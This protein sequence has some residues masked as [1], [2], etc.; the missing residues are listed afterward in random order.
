LETGVLRFLKPGVGEVLGPGACS[1][2]AYP[3]SR[4][5]RGGRSHKIARQ[6]G[7]ARS[8]TASTPPA[9][10]GQAVAVLL[11]SSTLRPA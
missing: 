2:G 11:I 7:G 6:F 3:E 4:G 10:G 8:G 9:P 5:V 1:L